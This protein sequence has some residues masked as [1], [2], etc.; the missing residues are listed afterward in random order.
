MI[1]GGVTGDGAAAAAALG[2]PLKSL[3]QTLAAL[4]SGVQERWFARLWLLKAP[5][6]A[7]LSGFWIAS[8]V[9]TLLDP[10]AAVAAGAAQ[11]YA[12]PAV[13]VVAG[14]WLDIALGLA[15]LVRPAAR[16]ALTGMILASLGYLA[17][18]TLLA[19][20]LWLDPL[21]PLVKVFPAILLALV[22]LAILDDR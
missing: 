19:P 15:L 2:R 9:I 22:A 21:G 18:G 5:V 20:G 14:G 10:A 11:G 8:G 12:P 13:L 7:T 1:Q 17:A 4:P 3:P 16:A 6:I